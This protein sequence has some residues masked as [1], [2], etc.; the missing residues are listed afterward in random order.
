MNTKAKLSRRDFMK[1]AALGA[2]SLSLVAGCTTPR[3]TDRMFLSD[4]EASVMGSI[5]DQIIPPDE[6]PGGR[7]AGVVTFIDRQLAGPYRRFQQD[8]RK[9]LAAITDTC[10]RRYGKHFEALTGGQQTSFLQDMES[11]RLEEGTW[12]NG[13]HRRFFELL[14]SHSLQ[15]YYGSPRHGGNKNYASYK[16]MGLDYPQI[17]GQ[18]R[19]GSNL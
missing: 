14:R 11:G 5:A 1:V 19:K 3:Q 8:Y 17:I 2:G 12:K 15:A 16:M 7:D 13:F 6:W 10:V 18:N 9:G 4:D